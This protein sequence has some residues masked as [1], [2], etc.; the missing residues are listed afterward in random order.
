[1]PRAL[2]LL[3]RLRLTGWFRRIVMTF[4]TTKGALLTIFSLLVVGSW[5]MMTC[6]GATVSGGEGVGL[7]TLEKVNRFAPFA[8]L[9]YCALILSSSSGVPIHFSPAEIQ[10]LFSGPFTRRQLLTYKL[11][12]QFLLSLIFVIFMSV[13]LRHIAG[14]ILQA[15]VTAF[16]R[17]TFMQMFALAV[18][19]VS[20]TI[21]ELAYSRTRKIILIALVLAVAWAA[22]K[23][24]RHDGQ[25]GDLLD[26][27][28]RIEQSQILQ[29]IVTPF[30]W[31]VRVLTVRQFWPDFV[32]WAGT[33]LAINCGMVALVYLL[34]ASYLESTAVASERRYAR[35]A[36]MRS[37]GTL[38][39]ASVKA[40]KVRFSL[41]ML[42]W[43]GG[44]G[45]IA[46]RQLVAGTRSYRGF[47]IMLI[48][49]TIGGIG[50]AIATSSNDNGAEFLPWVLAGT[51]LFMSMLL[52]QFFAYDFRSDVDRIEVLKA[53]PVSAWKIVAGQMI[54]PVLLT[55]GF[56]ILLVG[57]I[58]ATLGKIGYLFLAVT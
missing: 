20:A 35:V 56:Q 15:F 47:A 28:E 45:P 57:L 18:S 22:G 49:A 54:T 2:W 42:P 53:L 39:A 55:S 21:G 6:V 1:M 51:G 36:R 50:P 26:T 12:N 9:A 48:A 33:C 52:G 27:L 37:A 3:F 25:T 4:G 10:F 8:F 58:Y 44:A 7:D 17:F 31:Y 16:L 14:S 40:G 43:L 38:G 11:V 13:G 34:D 5:L 30:R 46:W 23:A 32:Q 19:F 41:P 24:L 29:W